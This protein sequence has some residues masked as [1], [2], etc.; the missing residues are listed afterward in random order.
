M[1][2]GD[3]SLDKE[4]VDATQVIKDESDATENFLDSNLKNQ[5]FLRNS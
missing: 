5:N 4:F 1:E 2:S 3:I